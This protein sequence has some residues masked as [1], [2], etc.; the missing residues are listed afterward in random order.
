METQK[1]ANLLGDSDK[2]YSKFATRICYVINDQKNTRYGEG[3]ENDETVKFQIGVLNQ[4]FV[5]IQKHIF[6]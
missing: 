6:L 3:N 5:I 4:V 2:E 1:I